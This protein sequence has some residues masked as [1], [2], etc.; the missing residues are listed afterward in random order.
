[1]IITIIPA[2]LAS[3]R[4]PGKLLLD[5]TGKALLDHTI[6][7]AL[8]SK[9]HKIVVLTPDQELAA[10]V[11]A[12]GDP[13]VWAAPS[14]PSHPNGTARVIAFA[15]D[16]DDKTIF[17]NFQGDEPELPGHHIDHM[18][19]IVGRAM[20]ERVVATM[21]TPMTPEEAMNPNAVKVVT[22]Q[23]HKAMWFS[24]LPI[25]IGGPYFRHI[26]VYAYRAKFLKAHR[27][28]PIYTGENLEQLHWLEN[29]AWIKVYKTTVDSVGIDTPEDYDRFT[30]RYLNS[31]G[32]NDVEVSG[33]S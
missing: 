23:Y 7:R 1:M 16:Y 2:R 9:S 26:G 12:R 10:L 27:W 17:V 30:Q 24:R 3:T 33:S 11:D 32:I 4:L 28:P 14:D 22:D 15:K 20:D 5:R 18:A 19:E 25:P 29:G 21:A 6:D 13:R 8:E 31:R